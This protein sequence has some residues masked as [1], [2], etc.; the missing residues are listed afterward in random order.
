MP[1]FANSGL[2]QGF[3]GE[4]SE[5][6]SQH[7]PHSLASLVARSVPVQL[8]GGSSAIRFAGQN[9]MR[10]TGAAARLALIA[11]AAAR[12]GVPVAE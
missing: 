10:K 7:L 12:L 11:E 9:L 2:V 6:L 4:L 3:V 8:T 5:G 1:G